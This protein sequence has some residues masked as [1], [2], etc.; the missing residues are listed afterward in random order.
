[1]IIARFHGTYGKKNEIKTR[2]LC[3]NDSYWRQCTSDLEVHVLFQIQPQIS[4]V[5]QAIFF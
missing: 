3:V 5:M 1:M 4:C 2:G